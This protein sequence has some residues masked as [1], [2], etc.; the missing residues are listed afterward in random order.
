MDL[1][2]DP[3]TAIRSMAVPF[4][5]SLLVTQGNVFIDTFWTSNLGA[6]AVSGMTSAVPMFAAISSIGIGLST[7]VVATV[8]YRLGQGDHGSAGRICGNAVFLG[9]AITAAVAALIF[10]LQDPIIALMG[11]EDVSTEIHQY[12]LPFLLLSPV[13]VLNTVFGGMLRAEGAARRST[14]IQ[15]SSVGVNILLDPLLIFGL[16]LG[17]AGASLA[18]VLSYAVGLTTAVRWYVLGLTNV[19]VSRMDLKPTATTVRELMGVGAPR[20]VEGFVNNFVILVQRVFII[21]ASGTI[22]VSLFNVPFRYVSLGMCPVEALGM[23]SVPVIAGNYG[24]GDPEA[25]AVARGYV[26]K[27]ALIIGLVFTAVLFLGSPLLTS[28]FTMEDS[29]HE[30]Y[31]EF[32]WN[33]CAYSVIVPLFAVQSVSASILQAV[34]K[35]RHPMRISMAVGVF[36]IVVFWLAVPFGFKGIT[37]ALIA[38]YVLSCALTYAISSVCFRKVCDGI[39]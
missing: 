7:G 39:V 27:L 30:W 14:L 24:K 26:L 19:R 13:T 33:L 32:V 11:S 28:L 20:I 36:R 34:K 23:A 2:G 3:K 16:G 35:S 15:M 22:G 31:D 10:V 12:L 5:T 9:V 8:A 21:M 37:I 38:S 17:V 4:L 6:S 1:L 29:M 18:T 25:M